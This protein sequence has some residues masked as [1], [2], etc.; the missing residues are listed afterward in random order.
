MQLTLSSQSQSFPDGFLAVH[1][2]CEACATALN[3]SNIEGGHDLITSVNGAVPSAVKEPVV[4][5]QKP[6]KMTVKIYIVFYST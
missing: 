4:E 6:A 1:S 2:Y 5:I 3:L